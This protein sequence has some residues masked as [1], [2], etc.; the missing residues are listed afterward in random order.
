VPSERLAE[1]GQ[2]AVAQRVGL[3]A[4]RE[5]VGDRLLGGEQ[6]V[7]AADAAAHSGPLELAREHVVQLGEVRDARD[8]IRHAAQDRGQVPAPQVRRDG[9]EGQVRVRHPDHLQRLA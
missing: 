5:V 3:Q 9:D 4:R 6:L 2:H 8:A 1:R 7:R